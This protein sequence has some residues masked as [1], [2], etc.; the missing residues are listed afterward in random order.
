M[1]TRCQMVATRL[2]K[3]TRLQE[4][5]AAL[6]TNYSMY[7]KILGN[8][9]APTI[10]LGVNSELLALH[11]WRRR[12]T[13]T[14]KWST[15]FDSKLLLGRHSS[16]S[17]ISASSTSTTSTLSSC[18]FCLPPTLSWPLPMFWCVGEVW[19]LRGKNRQNRK[20]SSSS[21]SVGNPF[22]ESS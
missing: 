19:S 9:R 14:T 5:P 1:N 16:S 10:L 13:P 21:E 17:S 3:F 18:S 20:G 12:P 8:V 11:K 4:I 15:P 7:S 22:S 2:I 6:R